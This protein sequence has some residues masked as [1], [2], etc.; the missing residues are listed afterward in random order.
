MLIQ[1]PTFENLSPYFKKYID[2]VKTND[3]LAAL[4]SNLTE[5]QSI[6]EKYIGEKENFAYAKGKWTVKEVLSHIIDVER[7]FTYRALRFSRQDATE[8]S[9]YDDD[10]FVLNSNS[11]DRKLTDILE[12]FYFL[13]KSSIALFSYFDDK[14]LDFEGKTTTNSFSARSLGFV[15][16]GHT[17]HHTNV[18][19]ERYLL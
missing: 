18:L 10:N 16:V 3:L 14:M 9:G 7:V 15:I 1:K 6:F 17:I 2:L 19:Q 13:R 12:E 11:Q 4:E 5:T 8:L